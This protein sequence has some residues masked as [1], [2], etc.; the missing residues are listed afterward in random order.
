M[1]S[2][3]MYTLGDTGGFNETIST[4]AQ[5]QHLP[6]H[7]LVTFEA[8]REVFTSAQFLDSLG[9]T[10]VVTVVST[11]VVMV[12]AWCLA[13]TL[14]FRD[15][16]MSRTI[17]GLAV[18]PMFIPAVIGAYAIVT[19][20]APNGF[21]R[22][23]A[24]QFGW[25]DA[26]TFSY[27]IVGVIIGSIWSNLPFAVLM[28]S[29]GLASVPEGLIEAAKDVGASA[30]RRLWT[31]LVPLTAVP[32]IIAA[33]FTA[34]GIIGSFTLPYIVGPTGGNMLGP[35]MSSTYSAFNMPQQAQV[36]A[37]AV[38]ALASVAAVAYI[39]ANFRGSKKARNSR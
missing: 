5:H 14:R 34:I 13:L 7:G 6:T 38:F 1:V 23:L 19:F 36:M 17:A 25:E 39:W 3:L 21:V 4:I 8:Y 37:I 12:L 15:G 10:I 16:W 32:S 11:A 9:V 2:G 29:S 27:T 22:T 26:P 33:T 28:I 20:Y 31:I 30:N 24:A 18:V 35:L